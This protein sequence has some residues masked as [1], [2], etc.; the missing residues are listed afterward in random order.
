V[1]PNAA[2]R[3]GAARGALRFFGLEA[4]D[5]IVTRFGR[6]EVIVGKNVLAH[7]PAINAFLGA[8]VLEFTVDRNPH[9]QG[10]LIP[11]WGGRSGR[12]RISVREMP[13]FTLLLPWNLAG[14]IVT[15]QAEYLRKGAASS[16]P[17]RRCA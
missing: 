1:P 14:E 8:D 15:Q 2:H 10:R 6:A 17:Y 12:W 5:E 9:K 16:S 11:G 3:N 4:V 13:D 7:V